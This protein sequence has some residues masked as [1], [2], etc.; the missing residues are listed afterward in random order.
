MSAGYVIFNFLLLSVGEDRI[1]H[2][3][4]WFLFSF[5]SLLSFHSRL[6][7]SHCW[8]IHGLGPALGTEVYHPTCTLDQ[9]WGMIHEER[10]TFP[11]YTY[12]TPSSTIIID[13]A[14]GFHNTTR[15]K[16]NLYSTQ[17]PPIYRQC[18]TSTWSTTQQGTS[19]LWITMTMVGWEPIWDEREDSG[20][21]HDEQ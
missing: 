8:R 9:W 18:S 6:A 3:S 13:K 19:I 10:E 20:S 17:I 4:R 5:S 16:R 7:L 12:H 1:K 21:G 14:K 15:F 2:T 11:F